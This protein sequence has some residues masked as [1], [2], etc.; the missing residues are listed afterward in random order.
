L[1]TGGAESLEKECRLASPHLEERTFGGLWHDW[2]DPLPAS[3]RSQAAA[4]IQLVVQRSVF[5][6]AVHDRVSNGHR[7]PRSI[8]GECFI[9]RKTDSLK[10]QQGSGGR[11]SELSGD[12]FVG[13]LFESEYLAALLDA[14]RLNR[15]EQ[16]VQR[17]ERLLEFGV[18]DHGATP[19]LAA[20]DAAL[21]EVPD[22]FADGVAADAVFLDEF[23]VGRESFVELTSIETLLEGCFKLGP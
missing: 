3:I 8:Q 6:I 18:V 13:A 19:P 7:E 12:R 2:S 1:T 5:K 20:K 4:P 9:A 11:E 16:A 14:R 23:A 10:K 17:T 21:V 22:R 15:F